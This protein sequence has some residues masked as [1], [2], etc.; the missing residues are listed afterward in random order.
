MPPSCTWTAPTWRWR[1][2]TAAPP[3]VF[4]VDLAEGENVFK[5]QVTAEDTTITKTYVV[6]VTRDVVKVLVSNFSAS[7]NSFGIAG[8][9][10]PL[11][12]TSAQPF[13]TGENAGGYLLSSVKLFLRLVTGSS[14][15]EI[16][17]HHD[18]D[19]IPGA[20]AAGL[21]NPNP[22]PRTT[23]A[24]REYIFTAPPDTTLASRTTYWLLIGASAG[25]FDYNRFETTAEDP[26][27]D[28]EWSIGDSRLGRSSDSAAWTHAADV[29]KMSVS[30]SSRTGGGLDGRD[31]QR[32]GDQGRKQQR[33]TRARIRVRGQDLHG[34]G[35]HAAATQIRVDPTRND[36]N[37]T[38]QY[39]DSADSELT[40]ADMST[41]DVFDVNL[42]ESDTVVK[43]KVTAEDTTTIKTY[44]VTVTR[45]DFL[46][47]NVN[48]LVD[49][50]IYG[51]LGSR[52][53]V[54][55]QFMTGNYPRRIHDRH[56]APTGTGNSR[57]HSQGFNPLRQFRRARQQAEGAG[58][59]GRDTDLVCLD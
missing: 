33:P 14:V 18:E 20:L 40:D 45:V 35:G 4:D 5:V 47:S 12:W 30:G 53:Q 48:S 52:P 26:G 41:P 24:P 59:Y 1:T 10:A 43:I 28:P 44:Q 50:T 7:S 17:I 56:G 6:T 34:Q 2:P 11:K 54:A 19:G 27:H 32:P 29:V 16:R 25:S 15:P 38:I 22:L 39:L 36:D 3:D 57:H 51:V 58:Q 42:A 13:T 31:A 8:V 37:A 9:S 46:V 55:I 21:V 49:E 23:S